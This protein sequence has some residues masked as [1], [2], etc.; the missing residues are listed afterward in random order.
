MRGVRGTGRGGRFGI[1]IGI[2]AL[3]ARASAA[4]AQVTFRA[5]ATPIGVNANSIGIARPTGTLANDVM[6]AAIAV[7]GGSNTTI[8]APSGWTLVRRTNNGTTIGVATYWK[9]AG[10]PV[11]DPGPYAFGFSASIRATGGITSY[12]G[13]HLTTPIN[14]SNG[15]TGSS[16]SCVAP[17][18][19]TTFANTMLVGIF[20]IAHG[21][22]AFTQPAGMTER[23]DFGDNAGPNGTAGATDDEAQVLAGASGNRTA[24]NGNSAAYAAQ[25]VALA[26]DFCGD[27]ATDAGEQCD[28]GGTTN[29]DCCSST[30]QFETAGTVCR[31][32]GGV[33]DAAESCT[34]SSGT[35]PADSKLTSECRASAGACDAADSCDGVG[36]NCPA[37][38]LVSAGTECRGAGG[39]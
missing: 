27:G 11:A 39:V 24:V 19:T 14:V 15:G 21:N 30:C 4:D 8:T 28:D 32:S 9:R 2:L 6:L 17:G 34:G 23:W 37:D 22:A 31:T 25:L 29:G 10:T 7:R 26:P 38:D 12:S 35:C 36:N 3:L 20:S 13:V 16:S 5:A 33:C 1:A 18:V